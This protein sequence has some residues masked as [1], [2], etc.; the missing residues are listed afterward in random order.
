MLG[1]R[2]PRAALDLT[3]DLS[4]SCHSGRPRGRQARTL[5]YFAQ[6]GTEI[7]QVNLF[8]GKYYKENITKFGNIYIVNMLR[9]VNLTEL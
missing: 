3:L 5:S 2:R 8:T 1:A 9:E 7:A 4:D 6:G